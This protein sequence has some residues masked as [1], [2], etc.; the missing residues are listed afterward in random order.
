[1]TIREAAQSWVAKFNAFPNDMIG[2][3]MRADPEAWHEVTKPSTGDRVYVLDLPKDCES[4]EHEGEITKVLQK[5]EKYRVV[6]DDGAVVKVREEALEVQYDG[7]LPMWGWLWQFDDS[8]D[9]YW[10]E[11]E[12]GIR[13]LSNCGFRVYEHDEWGFFFGIDGAGYDFYD[14]HWIPLYRARGLKWHDE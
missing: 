14:G 10:V 4:S 12:D 8:C 9:T 13:Q 11:E 1:M 6:L 3:L 5:A 2:T 7:I